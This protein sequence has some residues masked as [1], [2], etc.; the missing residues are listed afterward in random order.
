[1]R[2]PS[3]PR[4]GT[5]I[6]A[7]M[8]GE[9]GR[10]VF[11]V[12]GH[13]LDPRAEGTNALLKSG[14]TLATE[15][16]DVIGTLAPM[17]QTKLLLGEPDTSQA[18]AY[19]PDTRAELPQVGDADRERLLAALGPAPVDVD[20]LA[21]ATGLPARVIQVG[22]LELAL[23]GRIERHGHQLVSLRG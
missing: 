6:T 12:P 16:E 2:E 1:M 21:R 17:L 20:A 10:E 13:P 11:A 4:S 5:L 3:S 19:V 8:A 9:Q 23:A 14:A 22:L 15:P 7:R 18:P